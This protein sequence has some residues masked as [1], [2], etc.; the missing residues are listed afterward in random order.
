MNDFIRFTDIDVKLKRIDSRLLYMEHYLRHRDMKTSPQFHSFWQLELIVK[1]SLLA[2]FSRDE[3]VLK[4]GDILVIP[5]G[6][7]HQFRY[8]QNDTEFYSI[9]FDLKSGETLGS[10]VLLDES[11]RMSSLRQHLIDSLSNERLSRKELVV[12]VKYALDAL[13]EFEYLKN[14]PTHHKDGSVIGLVKKFICQRNGAKLT[15]EEIASQLGYTR[16]HL[17]QLFHARTGESLKPYI[18][19]ERVKSAMNLIQFSDRSLSEIA[20]YLGFSDLFS[21]SKFFKRI[22]G[23]SPRAYQKRLHKK[24][25]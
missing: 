4:E 9:K 1:G 11:C 10:E 22:A 21:F 7:Q 6:I 2:W 5:P 19:Q 14:D 13:L 16:S 17:S 8:Q 12:A 25:D 15:V 23:E 20:Y 18:D 24:Q 3:Y